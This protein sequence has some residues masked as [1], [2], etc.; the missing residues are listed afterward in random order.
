MQKKLGK[1][2]HKLGKRRLSQAGRLEGAAMAATLSV[3]AL[4]EHA[5]ITV[6]YRSGSDSQCLTEELRKK[7]R[8]PRRATAHAVTERATATTPGDSCG[9]E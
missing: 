9:G 6:A 8:L 2:R 3:K 1:H 7:T 4:A 5:H